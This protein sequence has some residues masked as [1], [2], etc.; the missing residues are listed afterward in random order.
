MRV[1][2]SNILNKALQVIADEPIWLYR[3]KSST[4][5]D[6]GI[7]NATYAPRV[8]VVGSVQAVPREKYSQMGLDF[9]KVY[10]TVFAST[11]IVGI[12]RDRSAA[13]I[14]YKGI[15]YEAVEEGGWFDMDGWSGVL[16][17]RL[18]N[19]G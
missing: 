19:D 3:Y 4:L 7:E 13:Q 16:F 10:I 1:P 6:L 11:S 5:N 9:K 15:R 12:D 14:T 2:G 17:V 18:G 8:K